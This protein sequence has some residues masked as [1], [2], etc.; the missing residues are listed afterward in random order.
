MLASQ[1]DHVRF[2]PYAE[3]VVSAR[4]RVGSGLRR[5]IIGAIALKPDDQA[6]D[7]GKV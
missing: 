6:S 4:P 2:A 7:V 3:I 1:A 5:P